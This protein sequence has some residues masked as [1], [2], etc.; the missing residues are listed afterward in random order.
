M[1]KW[2]NGQMAKWLNGQMAKWPNFNALPK[3]NETICKA[4]FTTITYDLI[5]LAVLHRRT[6][7]YDS[8]KIGCTPQ[9][10]EGL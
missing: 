9:K 3:I 10:N 2:P 5:K 6:K 4:I 8:I 7:A 1:A